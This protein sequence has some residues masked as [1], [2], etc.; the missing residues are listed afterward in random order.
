MVES[1]LEGFKHLL[2]MTTLSASMKIPCF[3]P[4][5]YDYLLV[6]S[7]LKWKIVPF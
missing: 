1:V 6:I 5:T 4:V 2:S 7:D 3:D